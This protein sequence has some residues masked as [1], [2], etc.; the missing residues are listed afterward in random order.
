M[1]AQQM[2]CHGPQD[3]ELRQAIIYGAGKATIGTRPVAIAYGKDA[4]VERSNGAVGDDGGDVLE[5]HLL[6]VAA[7]VERELFQ[8][9]PGDA[10]VAAEMGHQIAQRLAPDGEPVL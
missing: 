6:D 3:L 7:D 1:Q 5:A 4:I 10:A 9:L 2:A 8:F